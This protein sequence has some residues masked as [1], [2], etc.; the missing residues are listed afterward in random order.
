MANILIVDDSAFQRGMVRNVVAGEGHQTEEAGNGVDGLKRALEPG[1]DLLLLD[2]VM[3]GMTGFEVLEGLRDKGSK[4]PVIV[5]TADIQDD[6]RTLCLDL[7]A[8]ALIN[9]PVKAPELV[10]LLHQQLP[11]AAERQA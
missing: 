11:G 9:K 7:G 10:E 1:V 4:L 8:K 5:L 3:P 2:L 6:A